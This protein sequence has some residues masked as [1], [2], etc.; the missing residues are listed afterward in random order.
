MT[1]AIRPF[2]M[3]RHV[4]IYVN[5]LRQ[6]VDRFS[7]RHRRQRI[8][9]DKETGEAYTNDDARAYLQECA[10]RGI[11]WISECPTPSAD[12]SCPGHPIEG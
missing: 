3:G 5:Y 12:G 8:V 1:N 7:R 10:D 4:G 9:V 6:E 11:L 2:T